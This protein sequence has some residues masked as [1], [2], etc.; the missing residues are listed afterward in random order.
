MA[1]ATATAGDDLQQLQLSKGHTAGPTFLSW[2]KSEGTWHTVTGGADQRLVT[3]HTRN[4]Q[5]MKS[6]ENTHGPWNCVIISPDNNLVAAVDD[7][8]VKVCSSRL[9]AQLQCVSTC[10]PAPVR[11]TLLTAGLP[12]DRQLHAL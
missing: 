2:F 10:A 11:I 8:Y 3:R 1:E 7:Q 6:I 4:L 12:V 5:E 9:Q